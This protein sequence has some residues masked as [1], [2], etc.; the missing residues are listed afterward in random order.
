MIFDWVN[1]APLCMI[2]PLR[3][4]YKETDNDASLFVC[5]SLNICS[6]LLQQPNTIKLQN[7]D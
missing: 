2:I 5:F 6:K 3:S 1:Y 7:I 4:L